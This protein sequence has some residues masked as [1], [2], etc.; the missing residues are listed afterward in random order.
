LIDPNFGVVHLEKNTATIGKLYNNTFIQN[1]V[2]SSL[3]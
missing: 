2:K 3:K 1:P